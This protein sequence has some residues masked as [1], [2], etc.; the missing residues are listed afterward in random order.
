MMVGSAWSLSIYSL[1]IKLSILLLM[2]ASSG[3]KVYMRVTTSNLKSVIFIFFLDFII[4]TSAAST[5]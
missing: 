2:S 3:L 1:S 5:A 4:R